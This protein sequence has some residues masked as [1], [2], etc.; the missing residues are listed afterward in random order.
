MGWL[1]SDREASDEAHAT[2]DRALLAEGLQ[3]G[4]A[5]TSLSDRGGPMRSRSTA[6][7]FVGLGVARLYARPRTPNDNAFVESLFA[8]VKTAPAFPDVFPT[9]AEA[10]AYFERFFAWY[11][12]VHLHTRIGM[13]TPDQRHSGEWVRIQAERA[14]IRART[15]ATRRQVNQGTAVHNKAPESAVS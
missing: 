6:E 11:N 8:T 7:F 15:L 3:D 10:R 13:V 5:P 1:V 12:D 14:E 4:P 9:L 2:W